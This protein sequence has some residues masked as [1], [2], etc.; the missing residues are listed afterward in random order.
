[1]PYSLTPELEQPVVINFPT[2]TAPEAVS[3]AAQIANDLTEEYTKLSLSIEG[4]RRR[5][6]ANGDRKTRLEVQLQTAISQ[7]ATYTTVLATVPPT[8]PSYQDYV[9]MKERAEYQKFNAEVGLRTSSDEAIIAAFFTLKTKAN[10]LSSVLGDINQMNTTGNTGKVLPESLGQRKMA[11]L[12]QPYL[13]AFNYADQPTKLAAAEI[14]LKDLEKFEYEALIA[15]QSW[16]AMKDRKTRLETEAETAQSE[17]DTLNSVIAAL[18]P[19]DPNLQSFQDD[20]VRAEY[21]LF[22]AQS[23]LFDVSDAKIAT[24][25]VMYRVLQNQVGGM[26]STYNSWTTV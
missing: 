26:K 18:D 11:A 21:K 19:A 6:I 25:G 5:L 16:E 4:Q 13:D 22:Q 7:I 8:N 20:L 1:M 23:G 24:K 3:T 15:L 12:D 17:I 14:L 9:E 10:Q 2:G